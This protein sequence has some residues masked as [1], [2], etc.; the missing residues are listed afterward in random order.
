MNTPKLQPVD[1]SD[2]TW[3]P[4]KHFS[5]CLLPTTFSFLNWSLPHQPPKTFQRI[6]RNPSQSRSFLRA[7]G[8]RGANTA[9]PGR[10][11]WLGCV[12]GETVYPIQAVF[13]IERLVRIADGDGSL[14]LV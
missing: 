3:N 11:A 6:T 2:I 14:D 4:V 5:S 1:V 9:R 8:F 12:R 13:G 10:L 7:N